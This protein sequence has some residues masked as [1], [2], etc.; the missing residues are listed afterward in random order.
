LGGRTNVQSVTALFE[1]FDD[2]LAVLN[3]VGVVVFELGFHAQ[4]RQAHTADASEHPPVWIFADCHG[5]VATFGLEV[6][7]LG[8][9]DLHLPLG[10]ID[11]RWA[12][13]ELHG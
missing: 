9:E 10:I 13:N 11:Y 5:G 7:E 8:S 2:T 12:T 3:G 4:H 1:V 6:I